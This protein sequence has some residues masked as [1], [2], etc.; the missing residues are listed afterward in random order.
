MKIIP[1]PGYA[2][3]QIVKEDFTQVSKTKIVPVAGKDA[4]FFNR[5][6][7]IELGKMH[8]S[9]KT[10]EKLAYEI[11]DIVVMSSVGAQIGVPGLITNEAGNLIDVMLVAQ[12]L[13]IAKIEGDI[14]EDIDNADPVILTRN[15]N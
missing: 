1:A 4:S 11:G 6:K 15:V 5:M 9:S 12:E 2:L 13:I 10:G 7:I 8:F 14:A 3:L